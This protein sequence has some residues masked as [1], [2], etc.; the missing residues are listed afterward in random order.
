[1][2]REH[3]T[4]IKVRFNEVDSY[5]V[6]WHGHYVAWMEVGRNGLAG[7]F[8]L[9]AETLYDAGYYAPVTAL[10][11]KY[12]RPALFNEELLVR[13]CPRK[14]ETATIVFETVIV[15]PDGN[16]VARGTT[17]HVLTDLSGV[18]QYRLPEVVADRV[19]AMIAWGEGQ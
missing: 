8:G 9:D 16:Q 17:T 7:E 19:A 18:I 12:L 1:M 10:E 4:R 15:D 2:M 6:A 11:I 14:T 5:K 3:E 13:T